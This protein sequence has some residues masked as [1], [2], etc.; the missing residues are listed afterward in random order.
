MVL[1]TF[2]VGLLYLVNPLTGTPRDVLYLLPKCFSP[3]QVEGPDDHPQRACLRSRVFPAWRLHC[4]RLLLTFHKLR[5]LV[6]SIG[7][8]LI[9]RGTT[10]L[11][12]KWPSSFT[13]MLH[14]SLGCKSAIACENS[15]LIRQC[16]ALKRRLGGSLPILPYHKGDNFVCLFF[17]DGFL[18]VTALA[19]LGLTL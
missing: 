7:V 18:C 6:F 11:L 17:Q 1:S 4:W 9:M 14:T 15:L 13:W 2:R 5:S 10:L 12:Q 16:S 19:V 8:L 3:G